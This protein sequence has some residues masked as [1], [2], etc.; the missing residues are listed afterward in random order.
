MTQYSP[1]FYYPDF[2]NEKQKLQLQQQILEY[3][4]VFWHITYSSFFYSRFVSIFIYFV[5]YPDSLLFFFFF[6]FVS[7]MHSALSPKYN[8]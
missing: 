5:L 3:F 4:K 7:D 6:L 8:R 1:Y 2:A